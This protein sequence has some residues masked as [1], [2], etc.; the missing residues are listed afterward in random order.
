MAQ[1]KFEFVLMINENKKEILSKS[2]MIGRGKTE[3]PLDDDR[4]SSQHCRLEIEGKNLYI[5][6]LP[7]VSSKAEQDENY[8]DT[9]IIKLNPVSIP[10][11]ENNSRL[12]IGS[13]SSVNTS[14]AK[15]Q[16]FDSPKIY[17]SDF[18]IPSLNLIIEIK[19]SWTLKLDNEIKQKKNYCIKS[20]YKYIMIKNKN[21]NRF[22]KIINN[23]K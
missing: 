5:T 1:K 18:Y 23:G 13:P 21:Y 6:D 14:F 8:E 16:G 9:K 17:H 15:D 11:S 12:D 22:N 7:N 3:L 4:I 2:I 20:G 19:S 10:I